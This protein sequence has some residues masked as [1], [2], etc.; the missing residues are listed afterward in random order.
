MGLIYIAFFIVLVLCCM[1]GLTIRKSLKKSPYWKMIPQGT[2]AY[3]YSFPLALIF[4][5]EKLWGKVSFTILSIFAVF[6]F[7]CL[8]SGLN[9]ELKTKPLRGAQEMLP[10]DI[11][12]NVIT[13]CAITPLISASIVLLII[14]IVNMLTEIS[15]YAKK[16]GKK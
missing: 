1:H 7:I 5:S 14:L 3:G 12:K 11:R 13:F 10:D 15:D 9:N 8:V 6:L 4:I 16:R 2:I